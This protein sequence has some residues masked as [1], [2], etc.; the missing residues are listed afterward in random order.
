MWGCCACCKIISFFSLRK[1][2]HFGFYWYGGNLVFI[3]MEFF[4]ELALVTGLIPSKQTK[5]APNL[6]H[7]IYDF[8][9]DITCF[10]PK[11]MFQL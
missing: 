1:T 7:S 9:N 4:C 8:D 2:K 6:G 11:S 5:F 10:V 3:G